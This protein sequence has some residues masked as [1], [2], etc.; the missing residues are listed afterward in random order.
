[1]AGIYI[2]IPF[3]KQACHYCNFHFSTTFEKY[4][5]EMI[6]AICQEISL[7][8]DFFE[9]KKTEINTIYFGGGTPSILSRAELEKIW[10]A[11]DENFTL[12]KVKEVTLEANPDDMDEDFFELITYSPINRLSIG[13]QSFDNLD[14]AYLNRVHDS[15]KAIKS[16]EK[17]INAGIESISSDL[18][19][20]IP[21]SGITRLEKDIRTLTNLGVNHISAYGLTVEPNTSLDILIKKKKSIPVDESKSAEEMNWLMDFLPSQGY[22]QYETSNFAVPGSEAKHNSSYWHDI[23]YL[24]IGPSAHSYQKPVR[25]WNIANNMSYIRSINSG[26]LPLELETLNEVDQFNEWVM[27]KI[28]L[29]EG[30]HYPQLEQNF[31]KN[32]AKKF[33]LSVEPYIYSGDV[34]YKNNFFT[35]TKRGKL[36]TDSITADLFL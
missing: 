30:I 19:F 26:I 1:M 35:L 16:I 5:D 14:L 17:S 15:Q 27:T 24:G 6:D 25:A 2:H 28:R 18:I 33:I 36:I 3:C 23:P 7:R 4:R 31:G 32:I 13:V 12:E 29:R 10:N 8:K 22:E 21:T 20:G 9:K 11:L 34:L